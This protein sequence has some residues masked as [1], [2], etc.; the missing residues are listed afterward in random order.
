MSS[1]FLRQGLWTPEFTKS[2]RPHWQD[3]VLRWGTG[4][5]PFSCSATKI[6]Q[7][8]HTQ[9]KTNNQQNGWIE[10]QKISSF[11]FFCCLSFN[12]LIFH[13]PFPHSLKL[14]FQ[15]N[16]FSFMHT[17]HRVSCQIWMFSSSWASAMQTEWC[18]LRALFH[19][20]I[21]WAPL[22]GELNTINQAS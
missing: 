16:I 11:S 4:L 18:L 9:E 14:D 1:A 17:Y 13:S 10:K 8:K 2:E 5:G 19:G 20:S 22:I 12:L 21:V 7:A 6:N 3:S 15:E